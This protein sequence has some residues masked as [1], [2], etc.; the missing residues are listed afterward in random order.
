MNE[1]TR[2]RRQAARKAEA[3]NARL[4]AE[5]GPLFVDQIDASEYTDPEAE[6]WR[7]RRS[8]ALAPRG[9]D[10]AELGRVD[11]RWDLRCL[12]RLAARVMAPAD[13]AA[14]DAHRWHG[15]DA[16]F[17]RDVLTGR[18]RMVLSY[19]RHVYGVRRG[20]ERRI[21]VG[22]DRVWPPDGWW[23]PLD[24]AEFYR[25][26]ATPPALDHPGAV[27]PWRGKP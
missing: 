26:T 24:L 22:E 21:E 7:I 6:Y 27:D 25:L 20:V 9:H 14:A 13:F 3:K 12:R 4:E 5:A 23:A 17:W 15:D 8:W 2:I 10:A 1:D 19:W 11:R 16:D 18:R